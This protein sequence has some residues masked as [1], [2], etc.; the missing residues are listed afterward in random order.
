VYAGLVAD[1]R[2]RETI[3]SRIQNEHQRACHWVMAI[4]GQAAILGNVPVI[5]R[6]IELRNPYIDPLNFIQ[7]ALVK[8]LR[9]MNETAADYDA[10]LQAVMA[11]VNGIAAGMKTTG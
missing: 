10:T 8:E 9:Q 1:D 4:T 6:S 7:V 2:L 11:T 3:F 5:R